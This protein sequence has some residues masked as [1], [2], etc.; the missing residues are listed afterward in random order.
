VL[1]ICFVYCYLGFIVVPLIVCQLMQAKGL[2]CASCPHA[3]WFIMI[4]LLAKI[5]S[6]SVIM[7]NKQRQVEYSSIITQ[8]LRK[9][10][11]KIN[12]I[13]AMQFFCNAIEQLAYLLFKPDLLW[14][15]HVVFYFFFL[16]GHGMGLR[17]QEHILVLYPI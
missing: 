17:G 12:M 14:V 9:T 11:N 3:Y 8:V 4:Q 13:S 5:H 1:L 7:K 6:T 10:S 16:G 15:E 2:F